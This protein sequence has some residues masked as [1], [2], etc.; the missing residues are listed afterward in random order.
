MHFH[1]LHGMH[2]Y[3]AFFQIKAT[4]YWKYVLLAFKI[5]GYID[6]CKQDFY[7]MLLEFV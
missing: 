4:N 3:D 2:H 5:V 1:I 6:Y 7:H